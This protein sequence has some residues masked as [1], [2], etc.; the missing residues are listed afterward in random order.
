MTSHNF[1]LGEAGNSIPD[2]LTGA[3]RDLIMLSMKFDN[4]DFESMSYGARSTY[5]AFDAH[6]IAFGYLS[7][8]I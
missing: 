4:Q 2:R 8:N 7:I 1:H 5:I 3:E 6:I